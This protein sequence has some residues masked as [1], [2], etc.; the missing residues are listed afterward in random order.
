MGES[1][2]TAA[3]ASKLG[4]TTA[5]IRQW[6]LDGRLVANKLGRDWVID[7]TALKQFVESGR[8]GPG[9]PR[10]TLTRSQ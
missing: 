10:I 7:S 5:R 3:A 2:T 1:L 9:R 4:V 8:K 6:I